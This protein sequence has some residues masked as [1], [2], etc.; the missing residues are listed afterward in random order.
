MSK[1]TT[2]ELIISEVDLL[3][4]RAAIDWGR[5]FQR[6]EALLRILPTPM[7]PEGSRAWYDVA[8]RCASNAQCA[9]LNL[10]PWQC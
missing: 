2:D 8:A 5:D 3:A 9:N 1:R 7:P 4:L 6:K 10:R